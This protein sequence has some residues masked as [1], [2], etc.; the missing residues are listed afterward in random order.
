MMHSMPDIYSDA[1]LVVIVTGLICATIRLCHMCRPFDKEKD[2]FYPAR[3][4]VSAA[5]AFIALLMIPY[6]L[7]IR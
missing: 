7:E 2:Y 4:Q 1:C 6:W 3:I 5:Y